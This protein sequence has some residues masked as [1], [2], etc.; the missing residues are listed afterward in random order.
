MVSHPAA[1]AYGISFYVAS[2]TCVLLILTPIICRLHNDSLAYIS[3]HL[4]LCDMLFVP[5]AFLH[6]WCPC[7]S[8]LFLELAFLALIY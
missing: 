6:T 1:L 4:S 3:D 7:D 2:S 5:T 8:A